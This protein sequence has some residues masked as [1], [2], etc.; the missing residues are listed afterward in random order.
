MHSLHLV[1]LPLTSVIQNRKLLQ[2]VA[3]M[4]RFFITREIQLTLTKE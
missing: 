3:K 4:Q 2:L 1:S